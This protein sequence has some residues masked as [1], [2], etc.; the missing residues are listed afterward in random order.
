[1]AWFRRK[2]AD[3]LDPQYLLA[4]ANAQQP[5]A[6]PWG[7]FR[8]TVQ[9]VFAI[10]GRGTV[11]TGLVETGGVRVGAVVRQTRADGTVRDL[12]VAAIETS[13]KTIDEC[14]AGQQVGLLFRGI[15]RGEVAV[16]DVL[17]S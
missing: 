16:G 3:S 10:R 7:G 8:L 4:Q 1:M 14:A 6:V 13:R 9:D 11:V 2:Q 17:T 12:T 15:E 5:A